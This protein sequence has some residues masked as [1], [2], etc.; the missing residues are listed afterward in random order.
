M[1]L[2]SFRDNADLKTI[3]REAVIRE[4]V[5]KKMELLKGNKLK[6]IYFSSLQK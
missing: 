6:I 4:Q 1:K 3:G 5:L 2:H